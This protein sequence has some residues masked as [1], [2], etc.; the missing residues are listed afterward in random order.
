M[1]A[2]QKESREME[3]GMSN[4]VSAVKTQENIIWPVFL[5]Y[6]LFISKLKESVLV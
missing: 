2:I 6:H 4:N 3:R 5:T 1:L